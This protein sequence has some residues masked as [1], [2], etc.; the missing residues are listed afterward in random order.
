MSPSNLKTILSSFIIMLHY[1]N[2]HVFYDVH[3]KRAR[4]KNCREHLGPL[5][6]ALL[7]DSE[8][9]E[10]QYT[11]AVVSAFQRQKKTLL[12]STIAC[13]LLEYSCSVVTAPHIQQS[14]VGSTQG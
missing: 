6:S 2:V 14:G 11:D 4:L 13:T 3:Y 9:L 5:A 12:P 10:Y 1:L 7:N 8:L